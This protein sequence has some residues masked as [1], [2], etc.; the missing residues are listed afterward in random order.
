MHDICRHQLNSKNLGASF[1]AALDEEDDQQQ[2]QQQV[3]LVAGEDDDHAPSFRGG[4]SISHSSVQQEPQESAAPLWAAREQE[5]Q[6]E[7]V[8]EASIHMHHNVF[9]AHR[10]A[11]RPLFASEF[12]DTFYNVASED[13]DGAEE[14][15]VVAL[16]EEPVVQRAPSRARLADSNGHDNEDIPSAPTKPEEHVL[17]SPSL[18][19]F[20]KNY[21]PDS[22]DVSFAQFSYLSNDGASDMEGG[23]QLTTPRDSKNDTLATDI[24]ELKLD[25]G[26]S[27]FMSQQ[28]EE[29]DV[30]DDD[31]HA[32]V[33]EEDA[34][35]KE[36]FG[37]EEIEEI[38][39]QEEEEEE[40]AP[41]K[42]ERLRID[43][44]DVAHSL[45]T[46]EGAAAEP[47][48]GGLRE[49]T[50]AKGGQESSS[51]VA[52]AGQEQQQQ[53]QQGLVRQYSE[54]Q[55]ERIRA[56]EGEIRRQH[57]QQ[58]KKARLGLQAQE[59]RGGGG[60]G[61]SGS[62]SGADREQ[63]QQEQQEQQRGQKGGT[64]DMLGAF[65]LPSQP[66]TAKTPPPSRQLWRRGKTRRKPVYDG[67]PDSP[68]GAVATR[69]GQGQQQGEEGE[70]M[71]EDEY[72]KMEWDHPHREL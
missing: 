42:A 19:L 64:V 68:P 9:S 57:R 45:L 4:R 12:R 26:P 11:S 8:Q 37:D 52:A 65:P 25:H 32:L 34:R 27:G 66:P 54:K 22:S 7:A 40:E 16:Q 55:T 5:Q 3:P 14:E 41:K 31:I 29:E 17:P 47:D 69:Q 48:R 67:V 28:E 53:E 39:C 2:Q 62:G 30:V 56:K 51:S 10:G 59:G 23:D 50:K 1:T 15:S 70:D 33:D 38:I 63:H 13:P 21:D 36:S 24:F 43:L 61:G 18:D 58:R 20:E 49:G 71:E 60:G 35:R 72:P 46:K 44:D 6:E